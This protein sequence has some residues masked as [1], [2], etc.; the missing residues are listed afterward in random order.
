MWGYENC[1]IGLGWWWIV[2][3]FMIT[4]FV[5]CVFMMR[6]RM[7]CIVC[8]PF[9]RTFGNSFLNGRSQTAK[10]ILD[11]RYARGEIGNEEYEEKKREIGQT[12]G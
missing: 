11:K 3:V 12:E 5:L 1:C 2:P 8:G 10:E 4:M 6:K 9:S 7:G